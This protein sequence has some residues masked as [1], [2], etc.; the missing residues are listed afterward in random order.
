MPVCLLTS[1]R[2]WGLCADPPTPPPHRQ[3]GGSPASV[4][5]AGFRRGH[6]SLSL[7]PGGTLPCPSRGVYL[8]GQAAAGL[9]GDLG[10]YWECCSQI[11]FHS[12][13]LAPL[14]SRSVTARCPAVFACSGMPRVVKSGSRVLRPDWLWSVPQL[15]TPGE[16]GAG[17]PRA[18]CSVLCA[19]LLPAGWGVGQGP[20]VSWGDRPGDSG[21]PPVGQARPR[22]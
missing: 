18:S 7:L 11:H 12:L 22:L 4:P 15:W 19:R 2:W 16:G 5:L 17:R 20:P 10:Q 13:L 21:C 14:L 3:D 8:T 6:P 9:A 1:Q